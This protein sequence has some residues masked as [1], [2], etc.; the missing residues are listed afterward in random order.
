MSAITPAP[1]SR[2]SPDLVDKNDVIDTKEDIA[3]VDEPVEDLKWD[4]IKSEAARGEA[5]EHD[6]TL[7]QAIKYHRKVG[8]L[9]PGIL[10]RH[11]LSRGPLS[12]R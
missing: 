10:I 7:W 8:A 2:T 6:V 5:F 9:F 3:H 4:T 12:S 1:Q 11:R